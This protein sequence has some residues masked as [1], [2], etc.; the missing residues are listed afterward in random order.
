MLN[1]DK[2]NPQIDGNNLDLAQITKILSE[3]QR[4]IIIILIA[5]SLILTVGIFNDHNAK[6]AALRKLM[7]QEQGKIGVIK[8][9]DGALAD[10]NHYKSG[11]PKQMTEFE[12]ITQISN[13]A[14]LYHLNIASLSPAENKDMGL[15]DSTDLSFTAVSDDFKGMMLFLRKLEKSDS[16]ITINTWSGHEGDGG[17][18]SFDIEISAVHIHS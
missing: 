7:V 14:N 18:I 16:P 11:I 15:Y 9:R 10:L 1:L 2:M 3:H 6:V 5:I 17:K 4:T 13:D 12:L 8:T